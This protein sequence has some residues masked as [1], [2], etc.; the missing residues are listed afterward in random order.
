MTTS[1]EAQLREAVWQ[2]LGTVNDPEIL[3]PL[4]ELGMI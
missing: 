1:P 2:A 4:T 3:K